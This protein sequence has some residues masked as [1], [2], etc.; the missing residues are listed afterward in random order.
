MCAIDAV[1]IVRHAYHT[2]GSAASCSTRCGAEVLTSVVL[3]GNLACFIFPETPDI[4]C[5]E[6]LLSEAHSLRFT[7]VVHHL[8]VTICLICRSACDVVPVLI[9]FGAD[10]GAFHLV[11][12]HLYYKVGEYHTIAIATSK[13]EC[14]RTNLDIICTDGLRVCRCLFCRTIVH[15]QGKGGVVTVV[16]KCEAILRDDISAWC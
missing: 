3:D 13:G 8:T 5:A 2:K 14:Y 4:L 16:S 9:A 6:F 1:Y 12:L 11:L 15:G 10:C 7:V